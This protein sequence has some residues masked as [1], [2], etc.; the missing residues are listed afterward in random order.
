[1]TRYAE[2]AYWTNTSIT[3]SASS[4]YTNEVARGSSGG[5]VMTALLM[6]VGFGVVIAAT[7][8]Q[9]SKIG[10]KPEPVRDDVFISSKQYE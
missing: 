5:K 3:V 10:E 4:D 8:I 1:M 2:E 9:I 6:I 7:V